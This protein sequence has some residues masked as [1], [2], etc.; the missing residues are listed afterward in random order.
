M[1]DFIIEYPVTSYII[2]SIVAGIIITMFVTTKIGARI[3]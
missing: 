3:D 2:I 1:L